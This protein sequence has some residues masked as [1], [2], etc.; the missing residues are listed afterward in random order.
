MIPNNMV[1]QIN[2]GPTTLEAAL[3]RQARKIQP[4]PK[5]RISNIEDI[6]RLLLEFDPSRDRGPSEVNLTS[7]IAIDS[8]DGKKDMPVSAKCVG[9]SR[10]Q[11]IVEAITAIKVLD[12]KQKDD[13]REVLI[14]GKKI[15]PAKLPSRT[16]I[17]PII[18]QWFD[19][20]RDGGLIYWELSDGYRYNY[21]PIAHKLTR[22]K[23]EG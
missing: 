20:K 15:A 11:I 5:V 17:D 19:A 6:R 9:K 13:S 7:T 16:Y 8:D 21:D 1:P 3:E 14:N 12:E 2:P 4:A 23:R 18:E 22:T 10:R